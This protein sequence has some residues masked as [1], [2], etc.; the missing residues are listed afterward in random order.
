MKHA[1]LSNGKIEFAGRAIKIGSAVVSNPTDAQYLS[2]GWKAYREAQEPSSALS[3][4]PGV[5]LVR[6]FKGYEQD[7]AAISAV[8]G[9]RAEP[10]VRK[11]SKLKILVAASK[12]GL[13]DGVREFLETETLPGSTTR[14]IELW[15]AA[16]VFESTNEF[17]APALEALASKLGISP[18]DVERLLEDCEAD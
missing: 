14:L 8:W 10:V 12:A 15:N 16:Q 5:R 3:G 7:D 2:Q 13:W 17:F 6:Y 18:E 11:Y 4:D 1:R 9:F